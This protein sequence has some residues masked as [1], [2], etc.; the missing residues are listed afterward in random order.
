VRIGFFFDGDS[1]G[2]GIFQQT[3]GYLDKII[4]HQNEKYELTIIVNS[5]KISET[6]K[7]NNIKHLFFKITV[8]RRI[9][10]FL[11]NFKFFQYFYKKI[12]KTNPLEVFLKKKKISLLVFNSPSRYIFYTRNIHY[13]VN[14]WNTEIK[15]YNWFPEYIENSSYS[16]QS[17]IIE[18][19]VNY[20]FRIIVFSEDNIKDLEFFYNCPRG[21]IVTQPIFPYLPIIYENNVEAV[22]KIPNNFLGF[23][24]KTEIPIFLYPAQ[25]YAHKNH[26]FLIDVAENIKSKTNKE[27][28]FLFTGIDKGN[29]AFLKQITT[30]ANLNDAVK[31]FNNVKNEYLIKMYLMCD[32]LISS[33][34]IGKL[35]LPLLEAFYF[36]K[37]VFYSRGILDQN[38]EKKIHSFDLNNINDLSKKLIDFIDNKKNFSKNIH[39]NKSYYDLNCK[40]NSFGNTYNKIF[41]EFLFFRN[42]WK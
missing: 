14:I 10:F 41:D 11:L 16:N 8:F 2:G 32:A 37:P 18:E 19:A 38:L 20:S 21:K 39:N 15:N 5:A 12:K 31:F 6:L 30:R 24:V 42:K 27:F 36:Q 26:K 3:N 13:V 4:N 33:T 25:Y 40:N 23:D 28:L 22:N 34:Y 17:S 7:K 1:E 29:L 9:I 35:S